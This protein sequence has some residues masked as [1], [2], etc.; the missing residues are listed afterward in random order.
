MGYFTPSSIKEEQGKVTSWNLPREYSHSTVMLGKL[1]VV[2]YIYSLRPVLPQW[3]SLKMKPGQS[4]VS[5]ISRVG[6][7]LTPSW[8]GHFVELS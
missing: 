3:T 8:V 2:P 7:G 6:L 1:S 5:T 4:L